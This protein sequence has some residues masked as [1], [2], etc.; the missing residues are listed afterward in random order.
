MKLLKSLR[1]SRHGTYM[2]GGGPLTKPSFLQAFSGF[3]GDLTVDVSLDVPVHVV[4]SG[5]LNTGVI[6]SWFAVS[7]D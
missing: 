2:W 4:S 6:E 1:E 3:P 7:H 5:I